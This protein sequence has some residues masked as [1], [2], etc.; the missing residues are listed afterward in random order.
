MKRI[1][2]VA[3]RQRVQE[4]LD[5]AE[6]PFFEAETKEEATAVDELLANLRAMLLPPTKVPSEP[7]LQP[8]IDRVKA[9]LE[10]AYPAYRNGTRAV[11]AADLRAI[12][13]AV[14]DFRDKREQA[15]ELIQARIGASEDA[16]AIINDYARLQA[17]VASLRAELAEARRVIEPRSGIYIASKTKHAD[18][19]RQ[20][21]SEGYPIVSTWIDEAGVGQSASLADLWLRCIAEASHAEVLIIYREPDDALK[22]G[23][24]ELGAALHAGVPIYAVGIKEFTIANHPG[25]THFDGFSDALAAAAYLAAHPTPEAK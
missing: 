24:I 11:D 1:D 21:R 18:R 15:D 8:A 9:R 6:P 5:N 23:W 22:G 17:L 7:D 16:A 4:W 3:A 10:A 12:V 25:V 20:L 13:A 2:P 19:W 14:E